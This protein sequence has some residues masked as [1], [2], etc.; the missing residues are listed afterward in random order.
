M[1]ATAT[2]SAP[3]AATGGDLPLQATPIAQAA[4]LPAPAPDTN[5]WAAAGDGPADVAPAGTPQAADMA[6]AAPAADPWAA[7]SATGN[8]AAGADWLNASPDAAS[9]AAASSSSLPHDALA[10]AA[11]PSQAAGGLHLSQLWDGSLP[12]EHWI[13]QGLTWTVDH[14]RPA[15]Q[16]VRAPVDAT[17]GGVHALLTGLPTLGMVAVVGLLAWQFAGRALAL[18]AVVS[19]LL[20]AMLGIWQEAM[21]T[22]SLVLTSLA[23]CLVLGLPLGILLASSDRAQR[24]LRPALDAMQT[25][26]AFV[27]LVPVVMLFGIGNVPGVVVTIVFALPPLVRLT[28][29]GLRQVRPDLVEAARA[30]GASPVQMLWKVQLPLALPS[31]MAGVNQALMLSLSMVVIASMIA[32]GGLGQMV[33]RGIGRLDMGLATVGGLGIVLLAI[34]LDRITQALGQPKRGSRHWWQTGPVG[35]VAAALRRR[36]A[37]APAEPGAAPV[38]TL[39]RVKEAAPLAADRSDTEDGPSLAGAAR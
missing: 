36:T 9:G 14:F 37:D 22:L 34:T 23:F 26:P 18:G 13:N 3:Q 6:Q 28:N 27:Y 30:Y 39:A 1:N 35:L 25:T 12:V 32:V 24:L 16:A 33:L 2:H 29:L 10:G 21:V 8:D 5:P 11:D 38:A 4:P 20:V 31:I 7:T 19:L 17:L 15:F